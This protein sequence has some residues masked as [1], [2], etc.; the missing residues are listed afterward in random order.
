MQFRDEFENTGVT[1]TLLSGTE[2]EISREI[3]NPDIA[4][5]LA[6]FLFG[7]FESHYFS[8]L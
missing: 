1:S 2:D 5:R 6:G 8:G 4:V 3:R 7:S